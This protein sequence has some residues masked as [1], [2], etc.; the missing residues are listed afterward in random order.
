VITQP[1]LDL[2]RRMAQQ[3]TQADCDVALGA[4][5]LTALLDEI[6]QLK[7]SANQHGYDCKCIKCEVSRF[8]DS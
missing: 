6:E 7:E 2:L 3:A 8:W 1:Q 4:N 5:M